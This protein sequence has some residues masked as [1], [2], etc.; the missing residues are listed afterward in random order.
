MGRCGPWLFLD[1]KELCAV[2][3]TCLQQFKAVASFIGCDSTPSRG[4]KRQISSVTKKPEKGVS[5]VSQVGATVRQF[6]CRRTQVPGKNADQGNKKTLLA[7]SA[8]QKVLN[9]G[10][11]EAP[12][13][14]V[15][16]V[17]WD[18]HQQRW[19][20]HWRNKRKSFSPKNKSPEEI[21]RVC[22]AAVKQLGKMKKATER[23]AQL[24]EIKERYGNYRMSGVKGIHWDM[25]KRRWKV[26]CPD[27]SKQ[28]SKFF[29]AR[30]L[31]HEELKRARKEA[32]EYLHKMNGS[33]HGTTSRP[34]TALGN[35]KP[36][37]TSESV[38]SRAEQTD[39]QPEAP[40]TSCASQAVKGERKQLK[41]KY[42]TQRKS[43]VQGIYWEGRRQSWLVRCPHDPMQKTKYFRVTDDSPEEIERARLTAVE[44]LHKI[45]GS[46]HGMQDG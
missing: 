42:N 5:N 16:G 41:R 19:L 27:G 36:A 1:A 38:K 22:Q 15:P 24:K 21:K 43:G 25:S 26:C 3:Q 29:R 45:K 9:Q 12:K 20:V 44:H 34:S 39:T 31:S 17:N 28:K 7:A 32:V 40:P 2:S 8:E 37:S 46:G 11:S 4:Q 6:S 23:I 10:C 33:G 14:G 30:D 13:S 35:G 18:R